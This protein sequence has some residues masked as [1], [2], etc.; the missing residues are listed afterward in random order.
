MTTEEFEALL[1]IRE[2]ELK[3]KVVELLDHMMPLGKYSRSENV[4]SM[5]DIDELKRRLKEL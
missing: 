4:I 5:M 3:M 2:Q 1:L